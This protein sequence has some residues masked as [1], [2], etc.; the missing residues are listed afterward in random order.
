MGVPSG[1]LD[2][3]LFSATPS[4]VT[5]SGDGMPGTMVVDAIVVP[6]GDTTITIGQSGT[7]DL[8]IANQHGSSGELILGG[9][10]TSLSVAGDLNIGGSAGGDG[11]DGVL[12]ANVAPGD[13]STATLTVGGT[14]HVWSH[15][16]RPTGWQSE[17]RRHPD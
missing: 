12:L 5:I 6:G 8:D 7:G 2:T 17:R 10:N 9:V 15:R 11:G 4:L 3:A 1:T 14:V 13:Q 16:H